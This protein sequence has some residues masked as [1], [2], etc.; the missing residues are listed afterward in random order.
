MDGS[1]NMPSGAR[2]R[3]NGLS[4]PQRR[5]AGRQFVHR[6]SVL[7]RVAHWINVVCLLVLLMSGLQIFNAY[8]AL[9]WGEVSDFSS[10][11][12]AITAQKGKD[13]QFRG[14]RISVLLGDNNS[15]FYSDISQEF[16]FEIFS[17][18][19]EDMSSSN[20]CSLVC[21]IVERTTGGTYL[22]TGDTEDL[23][24]ERIAAIF[25]GSLKS[26][27]LAAP[28]HGSKNG[29]TIAAMRLIKPDTVLI[30][31]GVR[32][33]YGHPDAEA[34][35]TFRTVAPNVYGTNDNGGQSIV[36]EIGKVVVRSSLYN[37]P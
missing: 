19:R 8:P 2:D 11:A 22:V 23:R 14:Q 27:V 15:R 16:Y 29:I 36:T 24:W 26:N 28:H 33:K 17:P 6:H 3:P 30:S 18:H 13:G 12:F 25:G 37:A 4:R 34:V 1:D 31:A 21:R 20:N 7:V 10:P 9:S 32:N 35:R 5:A